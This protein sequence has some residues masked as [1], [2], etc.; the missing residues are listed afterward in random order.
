MAA[1][2]P[3]RID[4][5]RLAADAAVLQRVYELDELPRLR[6]LLADGHGSVSVTFAFENVAA[7]RAGATVA[8]AA[9]PNLICQRCLQGF[10]FAVAGKSEI[11]FA[12]S[13]DATPVESQREIYVMEDGRVNLRD[14]VEEELLLALPIVAACA[15]PEICAKAPALEND[16]SRPF[17]G[18][19]DL[20]KKT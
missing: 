2:L 14:L 6:D 1:G 15:A 10:P 13:E 7:G 11:E 17:A 5:A 16:R 8:V 3:D 18:L 20:L 12:S 19:E 4:C 9:T